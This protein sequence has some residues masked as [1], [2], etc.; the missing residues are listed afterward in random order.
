MWFTS[1]GAGVSAAFRRTR[2]RGSNVD[3]H[4][5]SVRSCW[6][7]CG[8]DRAPSRRRC[9]SGCSRARRD[10]ERGWCVRRLLRDP[11]GHAEARQDVS[12]VPN[13]GA[14]GDLESA[15]TARAC[16]P[17]G[18]VRRTRRNGR[19]RSEWS[20][21]ILRTAGI[22]GAT[23]TGWGPGRYRLAGPSGKCRSA[24]SARR[25]RARRSAGPA[26]D[27]RCHRTPRTSRI[28][29]TARTRWPSWSRRTTRRCG[30][31]RPARTCG[32]SWSGRT[33][34]PCRSAGLCGT[35]WI[36][37]AAGPAGPIGPAGPSD[38]QVLAP[39]S[40]TSAAGLSAGQSYSLTR[41]C[42]AGKK[43][44]GGGW[45]YSVSTANQ[46]SRVAVDSYPSAANAWTATVRVHQ[47]FGG[48]VTI[49]LNVYAVCTV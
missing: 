48:A 49:T 45:T 37:G 7:S 14:A 33:F 11:H 40:G 9:S 17:A 41:T 34:G 28:R 24:G 2:I 4:D 43:I 8:S 31:P 23:W 46:T 13:A 44:L 30:S 18:C 47:N 12:P 27:R 10:S 1:P 26:W 22:H 32:I 29:G 3:D 16:R 15:G 6:A 42:P 21:G 25:I 38:S 35:A 20:A 19:A 5:R 39:V 36:R